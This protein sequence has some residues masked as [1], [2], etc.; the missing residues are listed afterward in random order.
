MDQDPNAR[1]TAARRITTRLDS[2]RWSTPRVI[3]PVLLN[4]Q[5]SEERLQALVDFDY[6]DRAKGNLTALCVLWT[7]NLGCYE[8]HWDASNLTTCMYNVC[9]GRGPTSAER[10]SSEA[11]MKDRAGWDRETARVVA[12]CA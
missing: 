2:K 10:K 1:C 8:Q 3:H 4:Q 9:Y 7:S 6:R 11:A 12:R 5:P